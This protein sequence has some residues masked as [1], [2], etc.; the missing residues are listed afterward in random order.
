M[1]NNDESVYALLPPQEIVPHRP[2]MHRSKHDGR[3]NPDG[4][5]MGVPK[6]GKA[7]FG[8][9]HGQAKPD[10]NHFV[11]KHSGEPILPD[12]RMPSQTKPKIKAPL[13]SKNQVPIMGL[14]SAKNYVTANAVENILAQP[15]KGPEPPVNPMNKPGF[16]KVPKYLKTVKAKIENEKAIVQEFHQRMEMEHTHNNVRQMEDRERQELISQLKAKWQVVNEG[17]QKLS[18][19]LDTP[20]KKTRKERYEADLVQ[21]EKDIETLSRRVV[22]VAEDEYY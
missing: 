13:P 19:T 11:K 3:V 1:Y 12:P 9:A 16:A 5:S 14:V 20:A 4:F 10:P 2:P 22:L 21:I 15:K 8:P 7:T 18:F 6:R 17:Y